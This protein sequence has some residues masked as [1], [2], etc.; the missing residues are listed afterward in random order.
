MTT[1]ISLLHLK[2]PMAFLL[3]FAVCGLAASS[4]WAGTG[5]L[6]QAAFEG[7]VTEFKW[8]LKELNPDLPA[9]WT[10]FEFLVLELRSSSPQACY[11]KLFNGQTARSARI[12]FFAGAWVRA[13][14]PLA[15]FKRSQQSGFDMASMGNKPR[16]SFWMGVG[17]PPGPLDNV[18]AIG[19]Q[20]N[21]PVGRPILEI[22]SVQL[23]QTDPGDAVLEPKPLV[24]EFGQWIPSDWPGKI[25]SFDELK[26]AWTD[27]EKSLSPDESRLCKFGGYSSTKARATGFFR[28][29]Q[30]DGKWWF[31]D[32]DGHQ[33]FSAGSDCI[34]PFSGTRTQGREDL[35]AAL[36]P[37][38][39]MDSRR[40]DGRSAQASFYTWNLW[41]RFGPDWRARW[42]DLTL[43]RMHDWGLNT[44]A[45][46]SDPALGAAQR[47][48]F[49]AT[50]RGWG[51]ESGWM[52]LPDVYDPAWD[53]MVDEAAA[54]QCAS[55][56]QDP[57][58][59]GYFVANEPPWPGKETQLV[60]MI[61]QGKDTPMQRQLKPY[62]AAGD[63]PERRVAFVY[64]A[65]ER[66]LEVINAA[67]RRHDPNHLNLGIRFGGK[68]SD[69][70]VR[71]ARVFDVYSQNIYSEAPDP[72]SLD[73]IYELTGRP[74]VIGE[75]HIGAPGRGLAAGLVQAADQLQ[76]GVAYRCYVETA[77]AHP[78]VIGTHWFQWLDQPPT[79]R[80]DG[81]N[82]NIGFV[83]VTDRPYPDMV[84][85][86]KM[87]HR[88][89]LEVHC[90][91]L[92]PVNQKARVH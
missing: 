89:L 51:L 7:T 40:P 76:R 48:P 15:F 28:V 10:P 72:K 75:F 80:M 58:L 74:I 26:K 9:D 83:D 92:P 25:K 27:E 78:A 4:C 59:L 42:L 11:L 88:R 66:M 79:G 12:N 5:V 82:Y 23:A 86:A 16:N 31:V 30:I 35:F 21:H 22:R 68:P 62:L 54:Q 38:D 85:A 63:S 13:A 69:E 64:R 8:S 55:R 24:D 90:G 57:W 56:K 81:E 34:I 20:M 39:L 36:P 61:L 52:G 2:K 37:A 18:E 50:L 41:R 17:R 19:V 33:F 91:K 46:W 84:E 53:Q 6:K 73:S 77:A 60:D 45:N 65:F 44:V 49:V 87:T 14:V 3:T 70:I 32:P 29:E 71:L 67:V 43:R 47:I 1:I